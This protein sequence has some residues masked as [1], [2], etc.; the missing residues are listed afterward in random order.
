M[1]MNAQAMKNFETLK[2]LLGKAY[3]VADVSKQF[4][5][6]PTI[7]QRLQD[8]IIAQSDFLQKINVV[9][10][11]DLKGENIFGA[12]S[13]PVTGRTNT[14]VDGRERAT[15]DV[16]SLTNAGYELFA[17][18]SDVHITFNTIDAWSKFPDLAARYTRYVQNR[19]AMDRELIGWYG[20]SAAADTD[21]ATYILMQDVNRGWM[22][23]M[24]NNLP[25]N[26]L[27]QGAN[28]GEIRIGAGGD[29]ANLDLA[30]F[31]LLQAIPAFL[32]AGLVALIGTDLIAQ[33]SATLFA[34]V[35]G[36]PTEKNAMNA[37]MTKLGGL[38]WYT[39]ENH[40][41]RGLV[42]TSYDNLSLY[43]QEGSWRRYIIENPKKNRV[44]DYNSRNEGY[45][46]E[47]PEK[48]AA[49]EFKNVKLPDGAG[50]WA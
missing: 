24:R 19:M 21:L 16:L 1:G 22:Q 15:R 13:G 12:A 33:E 26:I 45:V 2:G 48:F 38:D 9:P 29:Y 50:G 17:T 41:A 34:A 31:D 27:L 6:T 49:L 11:T 3:G 30:V 7:E 5:V 25:A 23:Y 32:R 8:K 35:A 37:A 40:P 20:E 46:V 43:Y 42:I 36:K 4:A 44:E 10:V 39:P 28:A 18:E 47:T 14:S